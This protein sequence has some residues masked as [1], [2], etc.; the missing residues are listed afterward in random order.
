[1]PGDKLATV[2]ASVFG[3]PPAVI[4]KAAELTARPKK[5]GKKKAN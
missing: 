1:M 4:K 2:A 5:K 3:A